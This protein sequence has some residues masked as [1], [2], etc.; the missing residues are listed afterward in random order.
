M[1]KDNVRT[2][3]LLQVDLECQ[4]VRVD[5]VFHLDQ[6]DRHRPL[7]LDSQERQ[8]FRVDLEV[9]VGLQHRVFLVDQVRQG[10]LECFLLN[11]KGG[12]LCSSIYEKKIFLEFLQKRFF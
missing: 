12:K 11:F 2:I 10:I 1:V 3:Q 6:D 7:V 5:L 9:Q 8:D 4:E